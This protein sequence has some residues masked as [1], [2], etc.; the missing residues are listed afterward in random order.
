MA[1][2]GP[3]DEMADVPP[4]VSA[5]GPSASSTPA[6][7][8]VTSDAASAYSVNA[9]SGYSVGLSV[10]TDDRDNDNDSSLGDMDTQSS[11]RSATSSVYHFVEEFGRTF[12]KYKEGKYFMPNDEQEQNRLDLQHAI[13]KHCLGGALGLAPPNNTTDDVAA[14]GLTDTTEGVAAPP[15]TGP[16]GPVSGGAHRVLDIGTGTGIWAID[17]AEQH[18]AADV[19]G[20]DLSPIQPEYVPPNCRFEIDDLD[21]DWAFSSANKF[22]YIHGRY[23]VPFLKDVPGVIQKAYDH[24]QPGGYFE[25]FE[26]PI[27]FHC[28]DDT[29]EGTTIKE[30]N[31]LIS[32]GVRKIGR[33]PL[34]ALKLKQWMEA[35]GFQDIQ[36]KRYALPIN[37]WPRGKENK[38]LGHMEMTNLLEVAHGATMTIFTKALGWSV[39]ATEVF[40]TKV[41]QDL[42]DRRIHAYLPA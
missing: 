33:D 18:P 40:L 15:S 23:I 14:G 26:G 36:E 16:D 24:L 29:L 32:A 21:D 7:A 4:S 9:M 10:D 37:P 13:A 25:L 6:T 34:A 11:T 8:P 3:H 12:H 42:R 19:L 30:W 2:D 27:L 39:E 20:T 22:D 38:L 17:Y 31:D 1:S 5:A 35:A 41:R 28:V